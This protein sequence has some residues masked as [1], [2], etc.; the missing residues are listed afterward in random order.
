MMKCCGT[1]KCHCKLSMINKQ[2]FKY[3]E[4]KT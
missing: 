3:M 1:V 4:M 2:I